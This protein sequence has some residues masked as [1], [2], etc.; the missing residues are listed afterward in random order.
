MYNFEAYPP[1]GGNHVHAMELAL[2]FTRCGHSV[3]TVDD[4]TMPGVTNFDSKA[5]GLR[6]FVECIDILY[7]R[8][9]ARFLMHWDALKNCMK[10]IDEKPVV[11]EINS[12]ANEALAYSWLS[13]KSI[14]VKENYLESPQKV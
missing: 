7:I 9:D 10:M 2:G 5:E 6:A 3:F 11:W 8:V 1:R 4:P 12:P 13:G 14:S